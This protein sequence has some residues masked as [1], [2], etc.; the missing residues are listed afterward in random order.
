M[1]RDDLVIALVMTA[2]SGPP[3][4][5][6]SCRW[7]RAWACACWPETSSSAGPPAAPP[8]TSPPKS[9]PAPVGPRGHRFL[10][11]GQ[12]LGLG[13]AGGRHL[14]AALQA[15]RRHI[16]QRGRCRGRRCG[17]RQHR[18]GEFHDRLGRRR[19]SGCRLGRWY[20]GD[21]LWGTSLTR[22]PR[23]GTADLQDRAATGDKIANAA[24]DTLKLCAQRRNDRLHGVRPR[25]QLIQPCG[26]T[27][28]LADHHIHAGGG[29]RRRVTATFEAQRTSG[30]GDWGSSGPGAITCGG[31]RW[32]TQARCLSS[33]RRT[34]CRT[35]GPS[36]R[37]WAIHRSGRG[38]D[39]GLPVRHLRAGYVVT[40]YNQDLRGRH[41]AVM[42]NGAWSFAGLD[43][44]LTGGTFSG[45][46][47][48]LAAN[49][50]AGCIAVPGRHDHPVQTS[51]H[52]HR[53]D[54]SHQPPAPADTEWQTW[55]W[56][57]QSESHAGAH[58][59][60]P[61][62]RHQGRAQPQ[63][64]GL[65]L[66]SA[67]DVP[68]GNRFGLGPYRP[69]LQDITDQPIPGQRDVAGGAINGADHICGCRA[70]EPAAD[71]MAISRASLARC[72]ATTSSRTTCRRPSMPRFWTAPRPTTFRRW[73][74]T[75]VAALGRGG[76]CG[77]A[78]RS[79]FTTPD[80]GAVI[81]AYIQGS[82]CPGSPS[83]LTRHATDIHGR[84]L[85]RHLRDDGCGLFRLQGPA[86]A[87][88][89]TTPTIELLRCRRLTRRSSA[90]GFRLPGSASTTWGWPG[91]ASM[92]AK[93]IGCQFSNA[94]QYVKV[95]GSA[96]AR[97]C[98]FRQHA[99]DDDQ[100]LTRQLK[101]SSPGCVFND[102]FETMSPRPNRRSAP[103]PA[104]F[105]SSCSA[106]VR[107]GRDRRSD[108]CAGHHLHP[109]GQLL[110]LDQFP[111]SSASMVAARRISLGRDLRQQ[112]GRRGFVC[113]RLER[114][115]WGPARS[116][117]PDRHRLC[118]PAHDRQCLLASNGTACRLGRHPM[119]RRSGWCTPG[120]IDGRVR[121]DRVHIQRWADGVG[122]A[123]PGAGHRSRPTL[124]QRL[125]TSSPC[126]PATSSSTRL[127][128]HTPV[129][130]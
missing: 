78:G 107:L 53:P 60:R 56:D 112:V 105:R 106:G 76:A 110:Q 3:S 93:T 97:T 9:A 54:R 65:R 59:C 87:P 114:S 7:S 66:D 18:D 94:N 96:I 14:P 67:S 68:A 73:C 4:A 55:A 84:R 35:R 81:S 48:D 31:N 102:Y 22:D 34:P 44:I 108:V 50:P 101:W 71:L 23:I 51:G 38:A 119:A 49:T 21:A 13:L 6:T 98:S 90:P 127:P 85:C 52:R 88:T 95:S 113:R 126:P 72:T 29:L 124:A 70:A 32:P 120:N 83:S 27:H 130:G 118:W 39:R 116:K 125:S 15:R 74:G 109:G 123:A 40:F 82:R 117:L 121:D 2:A 36:T 12:P 111:A 8:A 26:L 62:A 1:A 5:A 16:H 89:P 92:S 28:E 100:G 91:R 86:L 46:A 104:R 75:R 61:S 77:S 41:Q 79:T 10:R 17:G 129:R 80:G 58:R 103:T 42:S 30:A 24:V 20:G 33:R 57:A 25:P 11:P 99:R 43:G 64:A 122:G 37:K 115:S 47:R 128:T 69:S 63:A 19:R 45:P